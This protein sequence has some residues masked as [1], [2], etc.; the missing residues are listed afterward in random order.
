MKPFDPPPDNLDRL[1]AG[2]CPLAGVRKAYLANPRD[3]EKREQ[4]H[5]MEQQPQRPEPEPL[6][7]GRN[8][9]LE[10]ANIVAQWHRAQRYHPSRSGLQG[11]PW[12]SGS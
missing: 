7:P 12:I 11:T 5:T 8:N 1:R 2:L 3:D 9:T 4:D 6:P 10:V